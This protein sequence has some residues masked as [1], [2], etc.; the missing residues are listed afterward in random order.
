[1]PTRVAR[2]TLR[3]VGRVK[4]S[5]VLVGCSLVHGLLLCHGPRPSQ[6]SASARALAL[7]T[8]SY[9]RL[10]PSERA[11]VPFAAAPKSVH[12]GT[13]QESDNQTQRLPGHD[14]G[15]WFAGTV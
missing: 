4:L 6:S 12:F 11:K 2:W 5:L 14:V 9:S 13:N 8:V 10:Q 7:S 15:V 1:M 3:V